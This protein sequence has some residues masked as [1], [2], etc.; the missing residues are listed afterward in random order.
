MK[1]SQQLKRI[2]IPTIL[3]H[4]FC[5]KVIYAKQEKRVTDYYVAYYQRVRTFCRRFRYFGISSNPILLKFIQDFES[6]TTL[7]KKHNSEIIS[8]LLDLY[9]DFFDRVL[10]YPLD[11]QQRRSIISEEE[12][13]LVISSA[14]SGKTSSILG[15]VRYLIEIKGIDPRRIALISYTNKAS[16]ELTKRLATDGLRGYTFHKLAVDLIGSITG[17]KP[18]ICSNP[19]ELIEEICQKLLKTKDFLK[20]VLKYFVF[21]DD[22]E[23]ERK[24]RDQ[25]SE[26]KKPF[27]KAVFP[28]MD[29]KTIYVRSKQEQTTCFILSSLGISFRYEEP[30]EFQVADET[31]SQYRPDF[32]LYVTAQNG[33]LR[34]IYLELF[35]INKQGRVP[36]WFVEGTNKTYKEV[37]QIYLD[38]IA[39]KKQTHKKFKTELLTLTSEDFYNSNI[40]ENIWDTLRK[41]LERAGIPIQE[42][43]EEDLYN[44]LLPKKS[45]QEK[46]LIKLIVRFISL[47][48]SNHKSIKKVLYCAKI[49]KDIPSSWLIEKVFKPVYERYVDT[50][51]KRGQIDFTDAILQATEIC[52]HS[53]S[54]KYDYII[55]DEFQDISIDCC[56]FL[57]ELRKG[58]PPAKMYCV[59]DDWQSIY[60]F[61]G[62]NI[63]VFNQFSDYFGPQEIHRLET[64]YR[65]GEPLVSLSSSFVQRNNFQIRK[66]CRSFNP[67]IR[68]ELV[69]RSYYHRSEKDYCSCLELEISKIPE[70]KSIFLLGRYSFDDYYLSKKYQLVKTGSN[71]FYIIGNRKIEFLTVHKSKGLEADYVILLQ[72]NADRYGFPSLVTDNK[73]FNYVLSESDSFPFSEERRLFYVAITRAKIKTTVL[74]DKK[75]PSEFVKEFIKVDEKRAQVPRTPVNA[76]KIWTRSEESLLLQLCKGMSVKDIATQTGRSPTAITAR[77]RKLQKVGLSKRPQFVK[78]HNSFIRKK[79]FCRPEWKQSS[80]RY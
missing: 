52:R 70:D 10:H 54:G 71:F 74:Y 46:A 45:V 50:L 13:C 66:D 19:E 37:N 62:S 30:Y 33:S 57:Q 42:K 34:R 65:L 1:L 17:V 8:Y 29:G 12:N 28:D 38:G 18:S 78:S 76:Y 72:C 3:H 36:P 80:R 35:A 64:T 79:R 20:N 23:S 59:G 9:K 77:L 61:A 56:R 27:L 22:C 55:V 63:T 58:N 14:G 60:R 41:L 5:G 39:W 24:I 11:E 40:R 68:T 75:F 48:K 15:K 6:I 69:F 49:A 67:D 47:M 73:V 43:K 32:S 26:Q 2:D 21:Y 44:A 25:L 7:I 4:G 31:H 16:S 53:S 51:A